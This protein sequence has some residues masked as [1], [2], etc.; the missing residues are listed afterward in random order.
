MWVNVNTDFLDDLSQVLYWEA[1]TLET[2]SQEMCDYTKNASA[3]LEGRQYS[4]S[5]SETDRVSNAMYDATT[6][7][8][9]LASYTAN[10]SEYIKEYL[11]CTYD[12]G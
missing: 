5:V 3:T 2:G 4:L 11:K 7:M 1:Q 6:N 10:L 9:K 8:R 12:R